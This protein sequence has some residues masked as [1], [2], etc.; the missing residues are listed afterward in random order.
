MKQF[1]LFQPPKEIMQTYIRRNTILCSIDCSTR[2]Y[3]MCQNNIIIEIKSYKTSVI[4]ENVRFT[5]F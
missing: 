5:L 2:D 4:A 1:E 3:P